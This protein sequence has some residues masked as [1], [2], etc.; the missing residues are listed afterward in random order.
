MKR[1][2]GEKFFSGTRFD[3][4]FTYQIDPR[5]RVNVVISSAWIDP[6]IGQSSQCGQSSSFSIERVVGLTTA[7]SIKLAAELSSQIGVEKIAGV[8]SSLSAS[9]DHSISLEESRSIQREFQIS[10]DRCGSTRLKLF[11]KILVIDF[12]IQRQTMFGRVREN[13]FQITEH[14]E[15]FD[16]RVDVEE[17][18][19]SCGCTKESVESAAGE[20]RLNWGRLSVL[21]PFFRTE[22]GFRLGFLNLDLDVDPRNFRGIATATLAKSSLPPLFLFLAAEAETEAQTEAVVALELWSIHDD[23]FGTLETWDDVSEDRAGRSRSGRFQT[24][25]GKGQVGGVGSPMEGRYESP[26]LTEFWAGLPADAVGNIPFYR[27]DSSN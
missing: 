14:T 2:D 8:K 1:N 11:Q 23:A 27:S 24:S 20:I 26:S 10:S 16:C 7:E 12:L 18:V 13:R 19:E 3:K 25:G 9:S 21:L 15:T 6:G 5:L 22:T 17:M 4:A